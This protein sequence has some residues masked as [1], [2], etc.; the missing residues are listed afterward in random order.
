MPSNN[1]D[2]LHESVFQKINGQAIFLGDIHGHIDVIH[3]IL[4]S[5][6]FNPNT[7][8][9][10]SV[11]DLIDK[12]PDSM[13]CLRM[14]NE[15][16]F[17]AV[18]GNHEDFMLQLMNN[19]TNELEKQWRKNGGGW[20]F[21]DLTK[22]ERYEAIE[23]VKKMPIAI[24]ASLS[25]GVRAGIT[26]SEC[27]YP[28]WTSFLS[29]LD[30][31]AIQKHAMISRHNILHDK[32]TYVSDVD[33]VIVGHTPLKNISLLGNSVYLDT[34]IH[35]SPKGTRPLPYVTDTMLFNVALQLKEQNKLAN[36]DQTTDNSVHYT[37]TI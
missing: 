24:S 31:P 16:W 30:D 4:S 14:L 35:S 20:W 25:N 13:S 19:P 23:L 10:I 32:E 7:D 27:P 11:G 18:R 29:N 2:H 8:I 36:K 1:A 15:P 17:K 12:G 5:V 22:E 34:N 9:C 28:Q 26:H 6:S 33:L 3:E 21:D 37:Q